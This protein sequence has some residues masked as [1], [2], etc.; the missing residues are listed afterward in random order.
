MT[1]VVSLTS[2]LGKVG[3]GGGSSGGP[4]TAFGEER[5]RR[6][7]HS[8]RLV[9]RVYIVTFVFAFLTVALLPSERD[10]G[11]LH[12]WFLVVMGSAGVMA[13]DP[14][15]VATRVTRPRLIFLVF[16]YI[17]FVGNLG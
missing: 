2:Q 16:Q 13:L 15:S 17:A 5:R 1:Q 4:A 9:V 6:Y 7:Q 10:I 12:R 14:E 3:L 11:A 8:V